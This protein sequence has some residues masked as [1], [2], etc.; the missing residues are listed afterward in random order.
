M[1]RALKS[2]LSLLAIENGASFAKLIKKRLG[3]KKANIHI[4]KS[5]NLILLMPHLL[6]RMRD[7]ADD[8]K[9]PKELK[10]LDGFLLTYLYHPIDFL[11]DEGQGLFGYLDD[12]YFV[13]SVYQQFLQHQYQPATRLKADHQ[14]EE[15]ADT[16]EKVRQVLPKET[17]QIDRMLE[18][19]KDGRKELF[20]QM[21]CGKT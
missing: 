8:S 4:S 5:L 20:N 17:K 19:L 14:V 6:S 9:I 18:E 15:I 1:L 12:A 11:P 3:R 7:F 2:H 21:V 16:L 10:R 13:G